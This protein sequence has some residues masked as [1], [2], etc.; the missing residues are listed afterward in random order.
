MDDQEVLTLLADAIEADATLV[1]PDARIEAI[2][3]WDSV[4]WLSVMA[5]LDE[6]LE[7]QLSSGDIAGVATVGDLLALLRRKGKVS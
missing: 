3:G 5:A 1:R 2:P 6:R 4:G 7:V